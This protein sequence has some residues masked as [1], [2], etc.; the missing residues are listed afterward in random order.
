MLDNQGDYH[1]GL[2]LAKALGW[3][4]FRRGRYREGAGHLDHFLKK[5]GEAEDPELMSRAY[6][7]N[8][9]IRYVNPGL[10]DPATAAVFEKS[11]DFAKKA[12]SRTNLAMSLAGL[13]QGYFYR[14]KPTKRTLKKAAETADQGLDLAKRAGDNWTVALCTWASQGFN[15]IDLEFDEKKSRLMYALDCAEKTGDPF[16]ISRI[17]I[18]LG[19]IHE[20]AG[21]DKE[22]LPWYAKYSSIAE[23]MGDKLMLFESHFYPGRVYCTLKNYAKA[24]NELL[25]ALHTSA[26]AGAR[27]FMI[28]SVHHLGD[29]ARGENRSLQA[30][31]Y[32][33]ALRILRRI[34]SKEPSPEATEFLDK[35]MPR[36][37][38]L[39]EWS[40]IM[41]LT[42]SQVIDRALSGFE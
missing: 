18:S 1:T 19:W 40:S 20:G 13:S 34:P 14:G 27:A 5:S 7:Y 33:A 37:R 38:W 8:G 23:T 42:E 36:Q 31:R 29:T 9:I 25:T 2:R 26:E 21:R 39:I 28:M 35:L 3:Y 41:T 16:V 32:Y 12:G 15:R 6:L 24:R 4:W 17:L 10:V 11:R 22:A 30:V